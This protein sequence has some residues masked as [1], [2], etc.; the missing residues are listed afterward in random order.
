MAM[1]SLKIHQKGAHKSDWAYNLAHSADLKANLYH[2]AQLILF[3][4]FVWI[5][6][7]FCFQLIFICI[8]IYVYFGCCTWI[9]WNDLF[10]FVLCFEFA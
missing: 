2:L 1:K 8:L 10:A 7:Q 3:Y 4:A 5:H 9:I 6:I